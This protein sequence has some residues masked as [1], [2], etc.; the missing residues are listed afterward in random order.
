MIFKAILSLLLMSSLSKYGVKEVQSQPKMK[1]VNNFCDVFVMSSAIS[2]GYYNLM[3]DRFIFIGGRYW[4]LTNKWVLE[5]GKIDAS[6]H[7]ELESNSSQFVYHW[8]G[9]RFILAFET[10]FCKMIGI[11]KVCKLMT[12]LLNVK[13]RAFVSICCL[14]KDTFGCRRIRTT[15]TIL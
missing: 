7:L 2:Y 15:P 13:I 14:S 9:G 3:N 1:D 5:K 4:R 12:G 6:L 11:A 10:S 8:F